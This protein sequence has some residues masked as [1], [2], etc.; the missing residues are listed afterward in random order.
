MVDEHGV[1]DQFINM[2]LKFSKGNRTACLI[3]K[4]E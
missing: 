2:G 3:E 1:L 4:Y